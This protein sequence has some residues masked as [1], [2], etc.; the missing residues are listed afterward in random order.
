L[1]GGSEV[2]VAIAV[3]APDGFARGTRDL[4]T[5]AR[6]LARR[7]NALDGGSCPNGWH[8]P[9][10][11]EATSLRRDPD[12]SWLPARH[13][14]EPRDSERRPGQSGPFDVQAGR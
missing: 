12:R 14:D 5:I 3:S 8:V 2:G 10:E 6:W 7:V 4:T 9:V 11:K 1:S 13:V